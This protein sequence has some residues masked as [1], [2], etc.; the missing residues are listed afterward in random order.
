MNRYTKSKNKRHVATHFV[1][2]NE[3]FEN[4]VRCQ[5]LAAT[6]LMTL[7]FEIKQERTNLMQER[8]DFLV[9]DTL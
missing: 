5:T 1:C 2:L 6:I 4:N 8:S 7:L 3:Y 9:C